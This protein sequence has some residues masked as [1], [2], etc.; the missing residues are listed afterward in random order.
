M[1]LEARDPTVCRTAPATEN[2]PAKRPVVPRPGVCSKGLCTLST[3]DQTSPEL[4][5]S[6]DTLWG[7]GCY[8]KKS[9]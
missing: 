1:E 5:V 3:T 7:Q 9:K 6:L 4:P 8:Y 2:G